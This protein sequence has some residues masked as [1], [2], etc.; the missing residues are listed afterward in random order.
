[1]ARWDPFQDLRSAQDELAE[2]GPVLAHALG[3]HAR[4]GNDQATTTAWAPATES[5]GRNEPRRSSHPGV[6]NP[7]RRA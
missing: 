7:G 3:L 6:T 1:M 2:M 4:Q 5:T